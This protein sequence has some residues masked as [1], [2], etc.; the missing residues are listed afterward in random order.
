MVEE[1]GAER[2]AAYVVRTREQSL[3]ALRRARPY[4]TSWREAARHSLLLPMAPELPPDD[5]PV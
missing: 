5:I 2:T 1:L 4:K 3:S